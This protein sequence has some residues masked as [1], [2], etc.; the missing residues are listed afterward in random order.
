[1]LRSQLKSPGSMRPAR[2]ALGKLAPAGFLILTLGTAGCS[3]DVTRFGALGAGNPTTT[4]SI[5][6]DSGISSAP[7]S[8]QTPGSYGYAPPPTAE[9]PRRALPLGDIETAERR[10][11]APIAPV[12]PVRVADAA[13]R[14]DDTRYGGANAEAGSI[15]VAAGDTLYGI[16]RRNGVT[17]RDLKAANGL[18]TN[19]IRPGQTLV[20]PG[21]GPVPGSGS[22]AD[23]GPSRPV[24]AAEPPEF[25]GG[26]TYTVR[27]GDS[28]YRVSRLTGVAVGDLKDWNGITDVRRVMPGTVLQL[29]PPSGGNVVARAEPDRAP[30]ARRPAP[31]TYET[32]RVETRAPVDRDP[33]PEARETPSFQ[34]LNGTRVNGASEPRR[35]ITDAAPA[36]PKA[37]DKVASAAPAT[38]PG[39]VGEARFRWPARGRIASGFGRRPD[40][41]HNDGIDILV[42][43]GSDVLAAEDGVVAY[44]DSQLKAYGNLI[45][46]RHDNGWVSAYAHADKML[47]KRGDRVTRGQVIAKAGT[48]GAVD[49]PTVHFELREG[50]KPV[51]PLPLLPAGGA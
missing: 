51:D 9:A 6:R 36:A 23:S 37:G 45:L 18:T 25:A 15:T 39:S 29:R 35:R 17:V 13:P 26:T 1:M 11:L 46:I 2:F 28:L 30:A 16:A 19:T 7:L 48:T 22:L 40:G 4:G 10:D 27:S 33:A 5:E 50:S 3:A 8:E 24:P 47:V 43:M 21:A 12:K 32:R 38:P 44:A 20:L 34:V 49:Q 42:P 31:R 14:Y 41:S